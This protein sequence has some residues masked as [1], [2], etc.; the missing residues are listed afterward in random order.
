LGD[1]Q[2]VMRNSSYYITVS[3]AVARLAG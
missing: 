1:A 2:T 3:H